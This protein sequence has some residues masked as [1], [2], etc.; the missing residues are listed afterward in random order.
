[1]PVHSTQTDAMFT[2]MSSASIVV[3]FYHEI[4][5]FMKLIHMEKLAFSRYMHQME[6]LRVQGAIKRMSR[7]ECV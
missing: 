7:S 1:M 3:A 5:W 6:N 4:K 2:R